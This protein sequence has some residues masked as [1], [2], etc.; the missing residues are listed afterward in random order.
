MSRLSQLYQQVIIDHSKKPRNFVEQ[1][2][3]GFTHQCDGHNPLCGDDISVY[4]I[5][6]D[7]IVKDIKFKGSGCSISQ[8]SASLMTQN[9]IGKSKTEIEQMFGEFTQMI[10]GELP[11]EEATSLGKLTIFA[12]V[13][14]YPARVKCASLAW[15]T[16]HGA[17][18]SVQDIS[19]E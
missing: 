13:K 3:N 16:M 9:L 4:L 5:M 19:T 11:S 8:A 15:H 6:E 10:K 1:A 12:G 14:E 18:Q 7:E 17:L 2:P